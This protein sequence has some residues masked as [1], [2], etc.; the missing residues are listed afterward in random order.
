[1]YIAEMYCDNLIL[2]IGVETLELISYDVNNLQC[3]I[4]TLR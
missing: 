4:K 1:M 3:Y 2:M